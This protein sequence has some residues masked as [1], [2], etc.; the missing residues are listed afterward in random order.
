MH[1]RY[2]L[3]R[4]CDEVSS[5]ALTVASCRDRTS[6]VLFDLDGTLTTCDT[7]LPVLVHYGLSRRKWFA[8]GALPLVLAGYGAGLSAQAAKQRLL[9]LFF[10][11]DDL[12][13]AQRLI[14]TFLRQWLPS[15]LRPPALARLRYHISAG[16]HVIVVSASPSIYVAV[17][18]DLLGIS[19][20]L[21]TRVAVHKGMIVGDIVG[22]NL[23]G[24]AK[25][26]AVRGSLGTSPHR[27]IVAAYGN[28]R[29]DMP[30]LRMANKGYIIQRGQFW[31]LETDHGVAL[32]E[33]ETTG[34]YNP[35]GG[36]RRPHTHPMHAP[37]PFCKHCLGQAP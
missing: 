13:A 3:K 6:V 33:N 16:H 7:L 21:A 8:L 5:G 10:G 30:M 11:G 14:G 2:L 37:G 23:T 20:W 17:I 12:R 36:A 25:V 15:H 29:D 34:P 28:S 1:P 32:A 31:P 4:E 9:R 35:L 19:S 24:Q 26:R 22:D 27:S 18:A